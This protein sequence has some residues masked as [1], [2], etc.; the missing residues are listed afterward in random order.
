MA[1]K[2]HRSDHPDLLVDALCDVI[3][4]PLTD[5]F[6][7][8]IVAIPTRGIDRWLTERIGSTFAGRGVGD[9]IAA[10]IDFPFPSR[11]VSGILD[12]IP[13]TARSADAWSTR[14]VV[15]HLERIID[16]HHD[17][18]WMWLISRFVD[19]PEGDG[20]GAQ[21]LRAAQK[22]ARLF[23]TYARY[24]PQMVE[25][26][27][28]GDDVGPDGASI[29]DA[30]AWQPRLWRLLRDDI[31]TPPTFATLE[32]ALDTIRSG[33][34][35]DVPE[36][37]CVYG[38][39][40]LDPVDRAVLEALGE[41]TA[42]HLFIL[43]P[44]PAMWTE[45][46]PIVAATPQS[47][48]PIRR[49]ADPTRNTAHHPLLRSWGQQARELQLTLGP[50]DPADEDVR[51]FGDADPD[52]LLGA[53]QADI[54]ANRRP[55][56]QPDRADRSIQIHAC[57]GPQRQVE[58]LRDALL[59]LL[60]DDP[61][62]EPRDIVIMT[63]DLATY[64]PLIEATFPASSGDRGALPDLR[65]RIADRAPT[66][67]NP[68]LRFAATVTGLA[69][70]RI[71][72]GDVTQLIGL[73]EVQRRLR[74]DPDTAGEIAGL[75]GD[76]NIRWGLDADHRNRGGAG[77]RDEHTWDRGTKRI[78]S[79]VFFDDDP[80]RTV[81]DVAP[82]THVEGGAA[83]AAG[84]LAV[85]L[86]RIG[87]IA[88]LLGAPAATSGWAE[89]IGIAVRLLAEPE[90][91]DEWQWA[92]LDRLL[93]ETIPGDPVDLGKLS[94]QIDSVMHPAGRIC[95]NDF[96]P[97]THCRINRVIYDGTGI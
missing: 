58:A 88:G 93:A 77:R 31:G 3:Q 30:A 84:K 4:T 68:L 82:L 47:R 65:V 48:S 71:S 42:V 72:R 76:A 50:R 55:R 12:Q 37:L 11:V 36:R 25:A 96:F 75:V 44:S 7:P 69:G 24:R 57:Y 70:S 34:G 19:G 91:G 16:A 51:E 10:N 92:Q 15:A 59:H 18:R 46:A 32:G 83:H 6:A 74:I 41:T 52:T 8:E 27:A 60:A 35:I 66:R 13:G 49:A 67:T 81:D 61:T 62:L 33:T 22:I 28:A 79:G 95:N 87:T 80:I 20:A 17:E 64:A 39:A 86:E 9:G 1:L 14:T 53:L 89:R 54:R 56:P 90:W 5:P 45:T 85:L 38:A 73:P 97:L 63:P 29:E 94:D 26:W 43:H 78:L 40:G 21:R 2:I 23:S